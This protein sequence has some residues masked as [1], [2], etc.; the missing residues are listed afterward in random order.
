[1]HDGSVV[2]FTK[3][4]NGYDPSDRDAVFAYLRQHQRNG[5]IPTGLLFLDPDGAT[6]M[7][8]GNRTVATPLSE[9]PY[10]RLCPGAA[11]LAEL[12]DSYR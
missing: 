4:P 12:Q 10:E 11:A 5:V 8:D 2:R 6:E 9:L 7:H 1:M 3:I